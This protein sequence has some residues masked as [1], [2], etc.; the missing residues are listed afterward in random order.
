MGMVPKGDRANVTHIASKRG[1]G[2]PSGLGYDPEAGEEYAGPTLD[3]E[4]DVFALVGKRG[5]SEERFYTKSEDR[6]HHSAQ[7]RVNVPKGLNAQIQAAVSR[8]AEYTSLQSFI[9]DAIVHRLEF[10]QRRY[11]LTEETRRW[12]EL[13]RLQS[14]SERRR[15]EVDTMTEAVDALAESLTRHWE[16]QDYAMLAEEL[17]E[18]SELL[19]WLREP[20]RGQVKGLLGEWSDR[21]RAKIREHEA[22]RDE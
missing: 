1:R 12:L 6:H 20:Y 19:D 17:E 7:I 11:K 9:R 10:I 14:D 2:K 22:A 15:V 4:T 13:E 21:A 5:Y 3:P 18:G 8:V 16:A